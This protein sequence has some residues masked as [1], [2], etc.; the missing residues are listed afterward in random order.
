M[1]TF[2]VLNNISAE[3]ALANLSSTNIQLQKATTQLSSGLRI[4]SAGDD[5]AGLAVANEYQ[6]QVSILTQGELNANNGLSTLQI[7][8]G[9]LSN[10]STLVNRLAT[11]A[12]ESA[13]SSSGAVDRTA[14][15]NEFQS[16]LSEINREA[17][18]AGISTA[19]GFSV[20]VSDNGSNGVI[21][22]NI[23]AASTTALGLT[24]LD[25]STAPDAATAAADISTA[26][27]NLGETQASVGQIEN[28]LSYAV[29]LAQ[30]QITNDQAAESRIKD[31]DVAQAATDMTNYQVLQ[32][33]GLA[34]LAQANTSQSAVLR[35][36][37]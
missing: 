7:Q 20:F 12:T 31:A 24:G 15:N 19:G 26:I 8:D 5:A 22:G 6:A 13:S 11:L 27:T 37:Q 30:S 10:I 28:R 25:V 35:L 21:S 17:S 1:A 18:V 29:S 3:T 23:G 9:A 32:Q 16:V 33:S 34:A 4:N 2:S 14:I 36:L